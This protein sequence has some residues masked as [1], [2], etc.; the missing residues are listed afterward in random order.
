[1]LALVLLSATAATA[2][3][4]DKFTNL[5]FHPPDLTRAELMTVMR[6][7][8]FALNV[9]CQHC[10]VGGD[11]VSFEGVEF[12]KDS[13]NKEKARFMLRMTKN[14]NENILTGIPDRDQPALEIQC[15]TCHRGQSKPMLLSQ[16]MRASLDSDGAEA[17]VA[18]YR[19][20]RN[21]F[22]RAGAF[23]FGEWEVNTLAEVLAQEGRPR[24]A[25]AIYELN[26]EFHADSSSIALSLGNLYE[27]VEDKEAAIRSYERAL[28]LRPNL[29]RAQ[30]R[31]EALRQ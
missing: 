8:S 4:P 17:A 22:E 1:M 30:K 27:T 19:E 6:N 3:I 15:K 5:Q 24:D 26:A 10:H 20:L 23:D 12:D 16:E 7:F 9:R 13:P 29:E 18:R 11:G 28:E 2:Q 31:L 25:I 14:L 21:D